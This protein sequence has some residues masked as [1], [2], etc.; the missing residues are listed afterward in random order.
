V[1]LR[2][3]LMLAYLTAFI[4]VGLRSLTNP[5]SALIGMAILVCGWVSH[6]II[7][8]GLYAILWTIAWLYLDKKDLDKF[9]D[10]DDGD[11]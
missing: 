11:K 3:A 5:D 1:P 2:I 6:Q 8:E 7:R 10:K 4:A 9:D